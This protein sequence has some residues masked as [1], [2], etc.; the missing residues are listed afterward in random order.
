MKLNLLAARILCALIAAFI[1]L[2]ASAY[3]FEA[4]GIYYNITSTSK[5]TVAVTYKNDGNSGHYND[6]DTYSGIV[7]IPSSVNHDGNIYS[8]NKIGTHAFA[9]APALTQVNLPET[10]TSIERDAFYECRNLTEVNIPNG[11]TEIA[12][13][14]FFAC[15]SIKEISIPE[16]VT[17]IGESA[18][19]ECDALTNIAL[20]ESLAEINQFAFA[21]CISL[22]TITIPANVKKL[23]GWSFARS[24]LKNIE[25]HEGLEI[26]GEA[27]FTFCEQLMSV[28]IPDS[29][30]T[31][32]DA[33]FSACSSLES[34]EIGTGIK[35]IG[36]SNF[37]LCDALK[38]ITIHALEPPMAKEVT[39]D[40]IIEENSANGTFTKNH[41]EN[42]LLTV[43]VNSLPKYKDV[44]KEYGTAVWPNFKYY[45][46]DALT[47]I[48]GVEA[49]EG[50]E[51]KVVARYDLSGRP[52]ADDYRGMTIV[53]RADGSTAKE[54]LR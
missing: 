48:E 35:T 32:E 20:P 44:N 25:L 11:I 19:W 28:K 21:Y 38:S 24:G 37:V 15:K 49:A 1:S 46:N 14:T 41:Y 52:V 8:V 29:V 33:A 2:S 12:K 6:A 23:G 45:T 39:S 42:V 47:G 43:P 51:S 36:A 26:I 16:S 31:I 30:T 7:V 34:V 17:S 54:I 5:K 22:E 53:R 50:A 40:D 3:D 18:F 27:A 13:N 10:I 9:Q 4:D